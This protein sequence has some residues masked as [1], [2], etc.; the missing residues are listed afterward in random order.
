[1]LARTA[2]QSAPLR[3]SLFFAASQVGRNAK[4]RAPGI[5]DLGFTK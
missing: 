2:F 1:M 3:M 5:F 4:K